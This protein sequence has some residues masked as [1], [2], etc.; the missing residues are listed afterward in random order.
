MS[1]HRRNASSAD[2]NNNSGNRSPDRENVIQTPS[3]SEENFTEI[4]KHSSSADFATAHNRQL[5][6]SDKK[7]GMSLS[8]SRPNLPKGQFVLNRKIVTTPSTT[9]T[10]NNNK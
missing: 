5:P 8:D 1:D 7:M 2:V 9:T 6:N 4:R 3:H 10:N